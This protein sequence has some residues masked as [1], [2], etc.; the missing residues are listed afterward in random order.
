MRPVLWKK[1]RVRISYYGLFCDVMCA[2]DFPHPNVLGCYEREYDESLNLEI[3]AKFREIPFDDVDD[4]NSFA[5]MNHKN[6]L[7]L[8]RFSLVFRFVKL[9]LT[10]QQIFLDQKTRRIPL[11]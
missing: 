8:R 6:P 10:P 3:T 2:I 11:F 4:G 7:V 1:L 5:G 9:F